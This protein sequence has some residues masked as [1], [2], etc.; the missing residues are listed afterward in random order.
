MSKSHV[1]SKKSWLMRM[2]R[3]VWPRRSFSYINPNHSVAAW[4]KRTAKLLRN[5]FLLV[6]LVERLKSY[7][8][9]PNLV[10]HAEYQVLKPGINRMRLAKLWNC[11][12]ADSETKG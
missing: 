4:V 2:T 1:L 8:T 10:E 12:R 3:K 7:K 5:S 11:Y 9:W 6:M